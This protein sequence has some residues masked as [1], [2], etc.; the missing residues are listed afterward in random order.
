MNSLT[1]YLTVSLI[2]FLLGLL[3]ILTRK[4]AISVLMGIE[5]IL[6]SAGLNFVA[7]SRFTAGNL[8]GQ[9][10]AVFVIIVAAAEAAVAL[11]IFLNLYRLKATAE[12][13]KADELRG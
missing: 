6:N 7:F 12:V 8:N 9:T 2:L 10:A 1:T 13:D 4:N 3:A 11:A 5:L